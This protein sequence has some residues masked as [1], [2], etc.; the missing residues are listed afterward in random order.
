M[1]YL[2]LRGKRST[3]GGRGEAREHEGEGGCGVWVQTGLRKP[4]FR[5]HA[6]QDLSRRSSRLPVTFDNSRNSDM[7]LGFPGVE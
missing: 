4:L 1:G 5:K 7:L 2:H 6:Y 3:L